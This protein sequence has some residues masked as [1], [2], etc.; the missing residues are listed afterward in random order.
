MTEPILRVRGLNKRFGGIVVADDIS[1]D[2]GAGDILGLIGPNGAGKTSLFNLLT[3]LYRQDAGRVWLGG[4]AIDTLPMFK[5][6]RL[7]LSRTWQHMRLFQSMTVL[8]NLLISASEYQGDSMLRSLWRPRGLREQNRRNLERASGILARLGLD[9]DR[10]K[11]VSE[12]TFG[13]QKLIGMGRALMHGGSCLLL[14]EPMAGVEGAAYE[15]M[16]EVVREEARMGRAICVVEHN[17]SFIRDLCNSAVFMFN[18]RMM[19]SGSVAE[20]L[21]SEEL[22]QLYFGK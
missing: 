1:L 4:R 13:Q 19:R 8:D 7:G 21:A 12:L 10:D 11:L 20:L 16:K 9:R 17:V 2:V 15:T 18:G 5:R 14:D 6:A 22:S 3:G